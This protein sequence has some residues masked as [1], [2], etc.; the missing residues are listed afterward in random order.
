MTKAEHTPNFH[1]PAQLLT[2]KDFKD[3]NKA[4]YPVRAQWRQIGEKMELDVND[5]QCIP[6]S[7]P[8]KALAGRDARNVAEA[9][10]EIPVLG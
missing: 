2:T 8:G 10:L 4:V 3:V 1:L 5:L 7:D 6:A 9:T